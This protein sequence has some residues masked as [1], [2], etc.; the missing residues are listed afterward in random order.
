MGV[1]GSSPTAEKGCQPRAEE[2][3]DLLKKVQ[4]KESKVMRRARKRRSFTITL[5]D[6]NEK[7]DGDELDDPGTWPEIVCAASSGTMPALKAALAK[8]DVDV[9]ARDPRGRTALFF[10][11]D[12]GDRAAVEALCAR[13]ASGDVCVDP[14]TGVAVFNGIH[15]A[16]VSD[17]TPQASICTA[18][19]QSPAGCDANVPDCDGLTPIMCAIKQGCP[20]PV[21]R[22]LLAAGAD[23]CTAVPLAHATIWHLAC[24]PASCPDES[25]RV[26]ACS[27][28]QAHVNANAKPSAGPDVDA[29]TCKADGRQ[30]AL[31]LACMY[32]QFSMVKFLITAGADPLV[33]NFD[34][35]KPEDVIGGNSQKREPIIRCLQNAPSLALRQAPSF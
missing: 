11:I 21:L 31:H 18:L 3:R 10:A 6:D 4:R 35:Q 12:R 7:D 1:C 23:P 27:V 30:T 14:K 15:L 34:K 24:S 28:V 26:R 5:K 16:L 32:G 17:T 19:L 20:S 22:A 33:T 8:Q 9:D 29:R 2:D 13:G 25:D